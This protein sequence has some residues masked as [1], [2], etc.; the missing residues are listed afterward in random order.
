[1]WIKIL[2]LVGLAALAGLAI[3][4]IGIWYVVAFGVGAGAGCVGCCVAVM[5]GW[6]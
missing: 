4:L 1:M 3:W 6:G 5:S 2:A